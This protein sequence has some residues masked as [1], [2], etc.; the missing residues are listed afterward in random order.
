M[1]RATRG[2]A[3]AHSTRG[4]VL[5][6][7]DLLALSSDG[8]RRGRSALRSDSRRPS[9]GTAAERSA[10]P[11]D[12]HR[13]KRWRPEAH[14]DRLPN[15]LEPVVAQPPVW[16]SEERNVGKRPVDVVVPSSSDRV[17]RQRTEVKDPSAPR[18]DSSLS[19]ETQGGQPL[20]NRFQA[21]QLSSGG[22]KSS[23]D[24]TRPFDHGVEFSRRCLQGHT[25][26]SSTGVLDYRRGAPLSACPSQ[27]DDW[28]LRVQ[29]PWGAHLPEPPGLSSR[30]SAAAGGT[31]GAPLS[32]C[33]SSRPGRGSAVASTSL[34][35]GFDVHGSRDAGA[36]GGSGDDISLVPARRENGVSL[37]TSG[38]RG[39]FP[40]LNA[41]HSVSGSDSL[42]VA[43]R[44]FRR[45]YPEP[46]V[47]DRLESFPVAA[48]SRLPSPP[49][50]LHAG[51]GHSPDEPRMLSANPMHAAHAN[52][53]LVRLADDGL[54]PSLHPAVRRRVASDADDRPRPDQ[55]SWGR[56]L[57]SVAGTLSSNPSTGSS[58]CGVYAVKQSGTRA[59]PI[60]P[61][62]LSAELSALERK[63]L[64]NADEDVGSAFQVAPRISPAAGVRRLAQT[65]EEGAS[66]SD[67]ARPEDG[68]SGRPSSSS[69]RGASTSSRSMSN[70]LAS[71]S[72]ALD[73]SLAEVL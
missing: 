71:T 14:G 13:S 22:D 27:V 24:G 17:V 18:P 2:A 30:P 52:P 62:A 51:Q 11:P 43:P 7:L 54:R 15:N 35:A 39:Q 46:V 3:D 58:G 40:E 12:H 49:R 61:S 59:G 6:S 38:E 8:S 60:A 63:F 37:S 33:F 44:S 25:P 57:S 55:D 45:Q 34:A 72:C 41:V 50:R 56:D 70:P 20:N 19:F 28:G 69:R 36:A 16:H 10:T 48:D 23:P 53:A 68:S 65:R 9:G 47:A 5:A 64:G 21:Q 29:A 32:V 4:D 66:F 67:G 42:R 31:R 1:T 73:A 26:S